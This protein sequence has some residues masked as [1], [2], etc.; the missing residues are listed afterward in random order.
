MAGRE[1]GPRMTWKAAFDFGMRSPSHIIT[2]LGIEW[3]H[4][5]HSTMRLACQKIAER[6][7]GRIWVVSQSGQ[8][9]AFHFTIYKNGGYIR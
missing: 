7:A 6:H 8:D 1:D 3:A 2:A 5:A 9:A 4:R